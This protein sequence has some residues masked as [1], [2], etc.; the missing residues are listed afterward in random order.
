MSGFDHDPD[1]TLVRMANR[2]GEFFD[3]LPCHEEAVD[4]VAQHLRKFWE[5]RMRRRLY[6]YLDGPQAGAGLTALVRAAVVTR[7][8]ELAPAGD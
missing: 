8:E 5:P 1:Q 4:G 7:R 2:I 6:A 3:A